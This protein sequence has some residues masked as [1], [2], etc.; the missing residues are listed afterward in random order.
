MVGINRAVD[1]FKRRLELASQ[2]THL[3]TTDVE[4]V[5]RDML[6]EDEPMI[7]LEEG[8]VVMSLENRLDASEEREEELAREKDD[9]EKQLDKAVKAAD[10]AIQ[11]LRK[12]GR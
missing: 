4:F 10:E 12:L 1:E 2:R 8:S 6:E 9:L 7:F 5:L 11:L 3:Y